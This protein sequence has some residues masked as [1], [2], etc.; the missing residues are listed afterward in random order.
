MHGGGAREDAQI[1]SVLP[2]PGS[3]NGLE[4]VLRGW[5]IPEFIKVEPRSKGPKLFQQSRHDPGDAT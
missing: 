3:S 4:R 2:G 1:N 5:V